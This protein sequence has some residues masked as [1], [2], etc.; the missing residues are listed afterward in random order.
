M[1]GS[2]L[3]EAASLTVD[4]FTYNIEH[5][6]LGLITDRHTD[7]G[8]SVLDLRAATQTVGRAKRDSSDRVL[9]QMLSYFK[10]QLVVTILGFKRV[11]N[12]WQMIAIELYVD[13]NAN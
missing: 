6:A 13:D 1:Y 12:R 5:A 9:A 7:R 8:S 4:R 11:I 10:Y 2:T 3:F